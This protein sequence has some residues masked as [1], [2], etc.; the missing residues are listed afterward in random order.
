MDL[1]AWLFAA[2]P[3]IYLRIALEQGTDVNKDVEDLVFML[4][5]FA[6]VHRASLAPF[7]EQPCG[8]FGID[9][10]PQHKL[11]KFIEALQA[12]GRNR[13]GV[14]FSRR[15][16]CRCRCIG[17]RCAKY[18]ALRARDGFAPSDG[19]DLQKC[20]SGVH[21]YVRYGHYL[22]H[23]SGKWSH[24]LRFHFHSFQY[25]QSVAGGNRVAGFYENGNHYRWRRRA[26]HA[27]VITINLVGYTVHFD[28]IT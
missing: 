8:M 23:F 28:P 6:A 10:E 2:G 18:H 26:H 19:V 7:S 24:N 15:R 21:L 5:Y 13:D 3:V 14:D 22:A 9:V 20:G 11:A 1:G 27:S 17:K 25:G 12:T 16:R 4:P